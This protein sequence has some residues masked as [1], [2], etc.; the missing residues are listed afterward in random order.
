MSSCSCTGSGAHLEA[1][2]L[3]QPSPLPSPNLGGGE[4]ESAF[5]LA[6]SDTPRTLVPHEAKLELYQVH[7]VTEGTDAQAEVSVRLSENGRAVT[8]KGA[9]PDTLVASAKAYLSALN[10]LVARRLRGKL[11]TMDMAAGEHR[12][13]STDAG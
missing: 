1:S 11:D 7:A 2:R 3:H 9:D 10:K 5:A 4:K 6:D 13:H 8:A 12:I